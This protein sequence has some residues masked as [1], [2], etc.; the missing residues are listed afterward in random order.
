MNSIQAKGWSFATTSASI[1]GLPH[2]LELAMNVV[3]DDVEIVE[4]MEAAS[5]SL[6]GLLS[7]RLWGSGPFVVSLSGSGKTLYIAVTVK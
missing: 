2:A 5:K 1:E 4:Q 3:D 7:T 6:A